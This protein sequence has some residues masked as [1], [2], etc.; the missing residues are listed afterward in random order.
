MAALDC[1]DESVLVAM[2]F[3]LLYR[4]YDYDHQWG[5]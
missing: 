3:V 1:F 2:L 5:V 4:G